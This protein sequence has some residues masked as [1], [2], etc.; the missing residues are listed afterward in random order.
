MAVVDFPNYQNCFPT[1]NYSM[2]NIIDWLLQGDI[3][4]I[5]EIHK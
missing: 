1:G 5:T 3:N 2:D 4:W